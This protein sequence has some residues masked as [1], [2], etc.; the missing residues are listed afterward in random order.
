MRTANP[1]FDQRCPVCGLASNVAPK[2]ILISASS[3][4]PD[5]C[6]P[7]RQGQ[8]AVDECVDESLKPSPLEQFVEGGYCSACDIGFVSDELVAHS[9]ATNENS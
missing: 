6:G 2:L 7:P 8:L 5:R 1:K 4:D 3:P 9:K